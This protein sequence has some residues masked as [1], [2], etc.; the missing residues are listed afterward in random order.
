MLKK[1]ENMQKSVINAKNDA[2]T[3]KKVKKDA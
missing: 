3:G 2:K 1:N